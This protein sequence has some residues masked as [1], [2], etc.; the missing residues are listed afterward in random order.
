MQSLLSDPAIGLQAAHGFGIILRDHDYALRPETFANI[1]LLY[2]QRYFEYVIGP[3]VDLF[4]SAENSTKQKALLAIS[5]LLPSLPQLV[6]NAH[7]KRL[8]P[9]LLQGITCDE[10]AVT[11]STLTSLVSLLQQSVEHAGPHVST[12]VPTLFC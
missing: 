10:E 1:R 4:N 8:L 12:L 2:K 5:S 3:L 7:I 6:L 9:V 11:E